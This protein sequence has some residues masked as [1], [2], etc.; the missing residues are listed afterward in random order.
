MAA[1][2]KRAAIYNNILMVLGAVGAMFLILAGV[3]LAAEF[4]TC[5]AM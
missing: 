1:I 4:F 3:M 2:K 5:M